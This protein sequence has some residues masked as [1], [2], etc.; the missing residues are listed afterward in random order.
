[1]HE[2]E[3]EL[4]TTVARRFYLDDV[5]KTELAKDLD[6]SRFRVARLLQQAREVGLVTIQ[7]HD[8]SPGLTS[9]SDDLK[10]HLLLDDCVVVTHGDSEVANRR[11][12]AKAAAREMKRS[13]RVGDL[14]GVSWGRTLVAIGEELADLPPC[15][16]IQ[17]TGVV[18]NDL[19]QSPVEVIRRVAD[20]SNVSTLA[21]FC[22]LFAASEE[23]ARAFRQDPAVRRVLEAHHQL[24]MATLSLGSWDPPITQLSESLDETDRAELTAEGARAEMAGIFIRDDGSLVDTRLSGRRISVSPDD[25]L[26]TPRVLTAAGTVAKAPAIAAVARSGLVTSLV[27]DDLT[28][29]ELLRMPSV[30]AHALP[31]R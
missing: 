11:Q 30:E 9:L 20:R 16:L 28:A 29:L 27:T 2:D 19:R 31:R 24:Q 6:I 8:R 23:T 22:P 5:P 17:L 14:V 13:I 18:G 26:R 4:M 3:W 21:L 10:Q 12:L 25:L 15:T 7:V 1:M